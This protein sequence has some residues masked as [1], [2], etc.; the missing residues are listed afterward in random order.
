MPSVGTLSVPGVSGII[1]LL[2][3]IP[4]S[5]VETVWG[6]LSY[7]KSDSASEGVAP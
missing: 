2:D 4:Y 7:V 1:G 5:T 6:L 3:A